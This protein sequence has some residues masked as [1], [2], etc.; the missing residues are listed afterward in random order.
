MS[1]KVLVYVPGLGKELL[2]KISARFRD[3]GMH[4]QFHPA[5]ELDPAN[6]SGIVPVRLRIEGAVPQYGESDTYS[7]FEISFKDFRYTS[8]V[9]V[10]PAINQKLKTCT[11]VVTVR[12]HATHTS[13]FRVGLFFA[14]FLAE[15]TD[16]IVY[17]PRSDAYLQ[18]DE[19]SSQFG[20]EI[21]QYENELPAQDWRIVPFNDW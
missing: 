14:A 21:M 18:S 17:T 9:S 2:P 15:V 20:Q 11:K 10:E 6:D 5:F 12:M 4:V 13:A 3:V 8:P 19:A 1:V 16:G 7:E